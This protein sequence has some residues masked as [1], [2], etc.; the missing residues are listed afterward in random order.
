[1]VYLFE[2]IIYNMCG[3]LSRILNY[4]KINVE[5][6]RTRSVITNDELGALLVNTLKPD[7]GKNSVYLGDYNYFKID[8]QIILTWA[9]EYVKNNLGHSH[10][11]N[12]DC[13]DLALH[14]TSFI[15]KKYNELYPD[16]Y[17]GLLFGE[18]WNWF[19]D[20]DVRINP[21]GVKAAH[22][23]CVYFDT[24]FNKIRFLEPATGKPFDVDDVL[25]K[26]N[27]WHPY[28]IKIP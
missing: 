19:T 2:I 16:E 15:L 18:V 22:S 26:N 8:S 20:P 5:D 25:M 9:G 24:D 14:V 27:P 10:H 23:V 11:E 7:N 12:R 28:L 3:F 4:N 13:E 1:L 6:F 17:G 21:A